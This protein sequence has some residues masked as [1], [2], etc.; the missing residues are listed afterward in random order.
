MTEWFKL[1]CWPSSVKTSQK[2]K[3]NVKDF[4]LHQYEIGGNKNPIKRFSQSLKDGNVLYYCHLA[5]V[6]WY[7]RYGGALFA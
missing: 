2:L 3:K 4:R 6:G 7:C 1:K 5:F